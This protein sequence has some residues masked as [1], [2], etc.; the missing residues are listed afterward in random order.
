MEH[1]KG[2]LQILLKLIRIHATRSCDQLL[3]QNVE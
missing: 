1:T 3:P 2:V